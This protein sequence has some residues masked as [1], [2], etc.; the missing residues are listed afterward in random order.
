MDG[1]PV[2]RDWGDRVPTA[3][4]GDVIIVG[5]GPTGLILAAE[6][7]LA[8]VRPLVLERRAGPRDDSRA[9]C[10]H[11]RSM[12]ALD[13]RGQAGLF[14]R[15]GLPVPSFPLG[16]RGATINFGVL[17]SDFPYLLDIPQ[18]Q[19]ERLLLDR[20]LDLGAEVRW[21]TPV[22]A[23]E[24]D[25]AGVRVALADGGVAHADYVVGCDGVHSFVRNA[26]A[27][28]F[29]GIHNPGSVIL[30]DLRLD[31][32]A[33]DA[34]YGDLSASGM[35]LI[36]PFRDGFCR[37]VLYD[38]GLGDVPVS[39]P[40]TMPEVTGSLLRLAGRDF[41]PR[42]LR[43][44]GR[45]RSESR[46]APT[47]R[48]G[49]VLLAG[50]AAHAH[51]P[52]GAQGLNTGLQDAVNLGWKLGAALGGWGPDWLLD[53][54]TAERHPVGA[55]VLA[56][57]GRQF[58]LN[59]ARTPARRALRWSVHRML[60]PLP[61]VQGKLARDYAGISIRYPP[62]RPD[63]WTGHPLA[64]QRLPRGTVTLADG[65]QARLP[66]LFRDGAFVLLDRVAAEP[67]GEA[68]GE[69][70]AEAAGAAAAAGRLA[71]VRYR[72]ATVRLPASVLVRPDGYVAWASD[73]PDPAARAAAALAAARL[74]CGPGVLTSPG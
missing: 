43:W 61:P 14:A 74:W 45:Y 71:A 41:R 28:P 69:A 46:Q 22:T 66:E 33:M 12:E 25:D 42:D 70:A 56:L 57:S 68:A 27:I 58:R 32:L 8:G 53:S 47:Y 16:P 24:Q 37:V 36:F 63:G 18:S 17:D 34:A 60:V 9:I 52:A 48:S 44:S 64:G 39:Q 21:S 19:I 4:S 55:G 51:S 54:Y 2:D 31:G 40:V 30:A 6:L 35:L 38:Y 15:T 49:R 73:E 67:A 10:L 20:A 13:L 65:R 72:S 1:K 3:R 50:D 62:V 26:L 23:I 7:A 11:A 29:P 5:A 59:T